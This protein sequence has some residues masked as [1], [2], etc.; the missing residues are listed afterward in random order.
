MGAHTA[1]VFGQA[2]Y[3]VAILDNL[4]N[5]YLDVLGKIEELS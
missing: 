3:D 1:V 2:G 4:S 5:S